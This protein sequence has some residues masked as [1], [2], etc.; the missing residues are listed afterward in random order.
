MKATFDFYGFSTQRQA[1]SLFFPNISLSL[2]R[3]LAQRSILETTTL[4]KLIPTFLGILY[5]VRSKSRYIS[6]SVEQL[7]PRVARLLDIFADGG[8]RSRAQGFQCR[9]PVL[10]RRARGQEGV[11][12]KPEV[13]RLN[14]HCHSAYNFPKV[15]APL[16]FLLLHCFIIALIFN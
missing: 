12:K 1:I 6:K 16:C 7:M 11:N 8:A 14:L 5:S 2:Q 15:M 4:I 9:D 13:T 3:F 10:K